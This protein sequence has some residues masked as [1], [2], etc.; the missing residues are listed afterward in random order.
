MTDAWSNRVAICVRL[1]GLNRPA[2]TLDQPLDEFDLVVDTNLRGA[3][4]TCR[5]FTHAA[6]RPGRSDGR[7]VAISSKMWEVGYPGRAVYCE[8]KHHPVSG[9]ARALAV[10]WVS[11][12]IAV[13]AVVTAFVE[14]SLTCPMFANEHLRADAR[15][16]LPIGRVGTPK[17]VAAAVVFLASSHASL[18]AGDVLAVDSG[19][20]W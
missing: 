10:E 20:T 15:Q 1:A 17:K 7:I 8:S 18:V 13:N 9:F 3:H 2:S 6:T 5:T 12:G 4:L 11:V 16:R 14:T 19:W